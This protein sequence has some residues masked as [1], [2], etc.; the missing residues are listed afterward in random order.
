MSKTIDTVTFGDI[1]GLVP[2]IIIHSPGMHNACNNTYR[3][4][5][6]MLKLLHLNLKKKMNFSFVTLQYCQSSIVL[7]Q[8]DSIIKNNIPVVHVFG[9]IKCH[10]YSNLQYS[11]CQHGYKSD[12]LSYRFSKNAVTV[13][14]W[15][16]PLSCHR[17]QNE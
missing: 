8:Y 10:W 7:Q 11:T 1:Y 17:N 4:K 12:Q 6:K 5:K 9:W 13:H 2:N 15:L 3:C 16:K 14:I